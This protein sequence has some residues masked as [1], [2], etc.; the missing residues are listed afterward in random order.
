MADVELLDGEGNVV[1][2]GHAVCLRRKPAAEG[3]C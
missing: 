3:K 1:K 2:R